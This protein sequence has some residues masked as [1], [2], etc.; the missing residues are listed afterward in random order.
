MSIRNNVAAPEYRP[1]L[2]RP[3]LTSGACGR[4]GHLCSFGSGSAW[5]AAT[6]SSQ[7]CGKMGKYDVV[8]WNNVYPLLLRFKATNDA[9]LGNVVFAFLHEKLSRMVPLKVGEAGR[10][11]VVQVF[12][13]S[14][15]EK[16]RETFAPNVDNAQAWFRTGL[17][18]KAIDIHRK[19]MRTPEG[20]LETNDPDESESTEAWLANIVFALE[21][22]RES[23]VE[24][25]ALARENARRIEDA[26][27][28]I[29]VPSRT[30]LRLLLAP[31]NLSDTE[32]DWL[33]EQM[34]ADV[35]VVRKRALEAAGDARACSFLVDP[36]V[37]GEEDDSRKRLERFRKRR[38]RAR[39]ELRSVAVKMREAK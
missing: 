24:Q 30:I 37:V 25:E 21:P 13:R 17:K 12:L 27:A 14:L 7:G 1:T 38:A 9:V 11:D 4:C 3:E 20:F 2:T 15:L 31:E 19:L 32:S 29:K 22:S 33:S 28:Q 16:K 23:C 5:R 10:A 8:D 39:D 35:E 34:G 18:R 26:M 36:P 6:Q